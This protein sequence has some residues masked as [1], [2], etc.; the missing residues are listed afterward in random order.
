MWIQKNHLDLL[1]GRHLPIPTQIVSNEEF[2]PMSQ[3]VEQAR[4][5]K[6]LF[7]MAGQR[8]RR[9]GMS[10]REFLKTSG[11]MAT[12]FLAMNEVFGPVFNVANAEAMEAAAYNEAWPKD[13]FIFDAQTHHVK[14][15]IRGP[16]AMRKITGRLG[17]NQTLAGVSPPEDALHRANYLKEIFLD[18]DTVMSV[19]SGGAV[20]PVEEHTLPVEEMV[21]TRDTMNDIAGSQRMLSHGLADPVRAGAIEELERQATELKIDGWK[22]YTGNPYAPWRM[23]DQKIAYPFLEKAIELGITNVSVH[24][25]LPLSMRAKEF[26]IPDDIP[27]AAKDFPDI[28]FIVYHSGMRHMMANLPPTMTGLGD[29]GHIEWTTDLCK[30][31]MANPDMTNVYMELGGVFGFS[32]IT[33]PDVCG[34]LLGQIIQAFG[35][36]HMIWGT[37]C[38]WF[39]SPQWQIEAFRRFQIPEA[40]QEEYGYAAITD[41]DRDRVFGLNVAGLYG[42]DVDA[43]RKAASGDAIQNLRAQYREAGA[44]PSNTA[45]GWVRG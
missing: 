44:E 23:D 17:F 22:C 9:L 35:A 12:A 3:T 10:R 41:A 33:N 34:H 27:R 30:A 20:G 4:I 38:I 36:D 40:L 6:W 18:S 24:K 45:Y 31:R 7:E 8:A 15:T 39:G 29:N 32:V 42:V 19:M 25:G 5:E 28:N 43:A 26:F 2:Y 11:G 16:L 21:L 37:D 13:Q 14:D 1:K